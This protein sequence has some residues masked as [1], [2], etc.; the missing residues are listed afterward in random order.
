M[1]E[2]SYM[3]NCGKFVLSIDAFRKEMN[4]L[5]R[6]FNGKVFKVE[7]MWIARANVTLMHE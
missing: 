3:A 1:I 6:E 5:A 4:R 7:E 2:A